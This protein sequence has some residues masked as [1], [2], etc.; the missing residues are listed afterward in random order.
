MLEGIVLQE[1]YRLKVSKNSAK[2]KQQVGKCLFKSS[3]LV[4]KSQSY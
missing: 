3:D 4:E 2:H 1:I